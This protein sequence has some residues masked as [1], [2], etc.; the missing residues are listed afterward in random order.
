M[1][2]GFYKEIRNM[3]NFKIMGI[4]PLLLALLLGGCAK[5][6]PKLYTEGT[7]P[8]EP[9]KPVLIEPLEVQN[10]KKT[11]FN[12]VYNA[13]SKVVDLNNY[14]NSRANSIDLESN[15]TVVIALPIDTEGNIFQGDFHGLDRSQAFRTEGY[16][17]ESEAVVEK[18]LIRF[19]FNV[20][21]RSRF[22]AKLR[23]T[24]ETSRVT[25]DIAG[26]VFQ[27]KLKELEAKRNSGAITSEEYITQLSELDANQ[28][29]RKRGVNELVD[30][31]ELIRAAQ[32]EGVQAD[33]ILQLNAIEEYSGYPLNLPVKGNREVELYL[34]DNPEL[35]YRVNN[36][37]PSD[38]TTGVFR[39][40]FGAKLF[41]V[42][43]GQV[44]WSGTHE[45]NSLNVEDIRA[46]FHIIKKDI[47]TEK[48]NNEIAALN[49]EA[50]QAYKKAKESQEALRSLYFK[51]SKERKYE[52]EDSQRIQESRFLSS[53]QE[54]ESIIKSRNSQLEKFNLT[55]RNY[56]DKVKF[57][58]EI[59]DLE[60][61]PDLNPLNIQNDPMK[62]RAIRLH[63]EKLLSETVRSLLA[64]IRTK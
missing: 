57:D 42:Q 32:S 8:P 48:I 37:I 2:V 47:S 63:R 29:T 50:N 59:S 15:P 34:E 56:N 49:Q 55:P 16:I 30:M 18:E 61:K 20:V 14:V 33:Y 38:F 41:H 52:N 3:I 31:S 6:S 25:E 43:T 12:I 13:K 46:S 58:Y 17:N 21:D 53:I 54:H 7:L 51:G 62:E 4:T 26:K 10:S 36:G 9:V 35:R 23:T 44:V 5:T 39:V 64:T 60:V 11:V 19:G 27:V 24:R 22:E 45:L 28:K 1:V 40:V